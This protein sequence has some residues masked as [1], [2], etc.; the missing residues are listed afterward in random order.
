MRKVRKL[1]IPLVVLLGLSGCGDSPSAPSRMVD[2]GSWYVTG[3]RWPHDG[4]PYETS[5]FIV[6][7]DAA[8]DQARRTLAEIGE[9]LLVELRNDFD[10]AS[11][12]LF[13]FPPGQTKI[14]MY[15]YRDRYPREWGGQSY[16]GG[17][18]IFSLDHP[19]RTRAGNT[20][21]NNYTRVVKHE[22]MHVVESLLIGSNSGNLVDEWLSEGLGEYVAGGTAGGSVTS[23]AKLDELIATYG[24]LNPIAVH[25]ESPPNI[26]GVVFYYYYPMYELAVDYLLDP[27]GAGNQEPAIKDLYLD[28]RDGVIFATAFENR[29]GMSLTAYEAQF[30]DLMREFLD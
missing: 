18:L 8:S 13:R 7:S 28:V 26:D 17:F 21:I 16:Y 27:A 23:L 29:L 11:D 9:E 6:Y 15:A 10:I 4:R 2:S 1:S 14:H 12:G 30:F 22:L 3:F 20:E 19:G 24:E 5:H 25:Q